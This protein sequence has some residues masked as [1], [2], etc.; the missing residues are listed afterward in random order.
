MN[1]NEIKLAKILLDKPAPLVSAQSWSIFD[2]KTNSFLFGKMEKERREIASLTKIMTLKVALNLLEKLNI[3]END[4]IVTVSET[5]A[6]V[7]G[8]SA[9]LRVNDSFSLWELFH[10]LMLPSGNDAAIQI[11]EFFG[12]ILL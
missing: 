1:M 7:T 10:G 3:N 12:S 5:A 6:D 2:M 11:A 8:T 9:E 4:T